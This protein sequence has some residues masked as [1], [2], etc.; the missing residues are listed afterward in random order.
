MENDIVLSLYKMPQTIF[1]LKEISLLFPSISYN[2]LRR[3]M[4]YNVKAAKLKKLRRSIYAKDNYNPFEL[5]TKLYTPSYI[6]LES[7]FKKEGMVFQT[8]ESIFAIASLTRTIK[9]DG[10]TIIYRKLPNEV[11]LNKEGLIEIDNY[12]RATPERAFL[13]AVYL[14][15]DYHFDNLK[16]LNWERTMELK[17]I[18]KNRVFEKRVD[19][20]YKLYKNEYI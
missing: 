6:S 20:Y 14:Y 7:V 13:D 19:S 4:S 11:L 5:A 18:Y 15:K 12:Y 1:S 17:A 3:R 2:N 10:N 9:A 8:Y 16:P